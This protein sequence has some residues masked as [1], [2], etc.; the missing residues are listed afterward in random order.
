MKCLIDGFEE[1]IL[2]YKNI[3]KII[4]EAIKENT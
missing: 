2:S 3:E 1:I 4:K